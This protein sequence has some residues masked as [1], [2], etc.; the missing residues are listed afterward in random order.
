MNYALILAGGLGLRMG[1]SVD[2]PKQFYHLAEKPVLM[3]TL[4][5]F[6]RCVEISAVAVVCLPT[7][8]P[9]L[10]ECLG[11]YGIQKVRWVVPGGHLR[12]ESVYNGL[13]E[14]EKHCSPQDLVVVHD[15]VRPF[16]HQAV[17]AEN[18]R[19]A[20]ERGTAMT[21]TPATDT[22]ITSPDGATAWEAMVRD[23]TFAV[24]TPQTYRLG[25]GLALYRKA[26]A[27]GRENTIN[28]CELFLEFGRPVE[29]VWGNKNNIKL[30]TE[31]DIAFLKVLHELYH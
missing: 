26:Y 23:H 29:M 7:W 21:V 25:E 27:A 8:E 12:Q 9:Y 1:Q 11:R 16:V 22:L 2:L 31:D 24:Q 6:E 5:I 13:C 15:G 14:L 18:I 28:C 10:Q 30:T 17:I 20:A 19:V 3:H 4:D